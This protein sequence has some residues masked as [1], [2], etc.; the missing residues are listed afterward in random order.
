MPKSLILSLSVKQR[1]MPFS[2][3]SGLVVLQRRSSFLAK[4]Q[5]SVG[6]YHTL[7]CPC[8]AVVFSESHLWGQTRSWF[9][10]CIDIKEYQSPKA[11]FAL[12]TIGVVSDSRKAAD[13]ALGR[14]SALF[15][16][17]LQL[18]ACHTPSQFLSRCN[19][20]VWGGIS[21]REWRCKA[22]LGS[23]QECKQCHS[24]A[25]WEAGG[26]PQGAA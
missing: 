17:G 9:Q 16:P 20:L 7:M 14:S 15:Q 21:V 19:Q 26:I 1:R 3:V 11:F 23:L 5:F 10:A 13:A 2:G 25:T 18:A 22:A 8:S 4:A 12:T 6:H 24:M